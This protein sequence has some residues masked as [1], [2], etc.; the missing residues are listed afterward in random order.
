MRNRAWLGALLVVSSLGCGELGSSKARKRER[1][2]KVAKEVELEA[3]L[4]KVRNLERAAEEAQREVD[5]LRRKLASEP[6]EGKRKAI[7]LQL[8]MAE[9][10][11]NEAAAAAGKPAP[12]RGS[13]TSAAP[14]P[15]CNC[16]PTDPL[17]DC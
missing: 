2:A 4:T 16:K 8:L 17:C 15:P 13:S 7:E 11:A 9:K 6:E 1:E 3:E 12:P 10:K 5:D 14:R